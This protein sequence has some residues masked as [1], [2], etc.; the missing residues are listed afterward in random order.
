M[1]RPAS[2]QQFPHPNS[3]VGMVGFGTAVPALCKLADIG[4][5]ARLR[6]KKEY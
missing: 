2:Q 4:V 1:R 6:S 5:V 3:S